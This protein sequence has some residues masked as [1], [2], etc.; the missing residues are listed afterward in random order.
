M[1][2]EKLKTEAEILSSLSHPN[3]VAFIG[4]SETAQIVNPHKPSSTCTA[5]FTEYCSEGDLESLIEQIGPFPEKLARTYFHQIISAVEY[6]HSSNI[7]HLDIKPDNFILDENMC[8]KLA[9]FGA[10]ARFSISDEF[11]VRLGT[12]SYL[13]P[14]TF[15]DQSYNGKN[16][17]LF[18]CGVVLF[19]MVVGH[20]PFGKAHPDDKLYKLICDK[21]YSTFWNVHQEL[22]SKTTK[23]LFSQEFKDL[24][25]STLKR[26]PTERL[27]LEELKAHCWF[28]GPTIER[29]DIRKVFYKS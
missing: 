8:L 10:A 2:A 17:D 25:I 1:N 7:C 13:A 16:V 3:I 14:E 21:K 26:S 19:I 12:D 22:T 29:E 28:K 6:L 20:Y 24:S 15:L 27:S 5:I 11:K 9:D 23:K 18:A 4:F